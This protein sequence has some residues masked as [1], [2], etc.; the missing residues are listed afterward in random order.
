MNSGQP[1]DDLIE[2]MN[3]Y[4]EARAPWHDQ[5]MSYTSN[6]QLEA[7]LSPII[8][9][10]APV[11]RGARVLE[12]ACGTGNWTQVLAKRAALVDAFDQSR[13]ALEIA[14]DKLSKYTNVTLLNGDAYNPEGVGR[15]Y[16]LLF[17]A[18]WLSHVP[19]QKIHTF[20]AAVTKAMAPGSTAV[21]LDMLCSEYFQNEE[22][23]YDD[24]GNRISL[25]T[26]PDGSQFSVIK[27]F[28]DESELRTVFD[29]HCSRLT[30]HSFPDLL[31]WLVILEFK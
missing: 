19:K 30:Y 4:Y 24:Y 14:R 18:D 17:A 6:A 28:P 20:M 22:C 26:L 10:L 23:H 27:N 21:F 8:E 16:S 7:A 11:I 25:R 2:Q 3:R 5:Y 29:N 1:S 9:L 31:R 13:V 12:V 15:N